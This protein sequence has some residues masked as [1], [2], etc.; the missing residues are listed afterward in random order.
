MRIDVLKQSCFLIESALHKSQ[1]HTAQYSQ[2]TVHHLNFHEN[3]IHSSHHL[4]LGTG[5]MESEILSSLLIHTLNLLI[6]SSIHSQSHQ[7]PSHLRY[8]DPATAEDDDSVT[9]HHSGGC[10]ALKEGEDRKGK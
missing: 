8:K 3:P 5:E 9:L 6:Q 2:I 4:N 1:S 7:P 10:E